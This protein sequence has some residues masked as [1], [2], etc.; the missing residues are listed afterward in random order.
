MR[1][2][3]VHNALRS[4]VRIDRDILAEAHEVDE[5]DL[6][7]PARIVSLPARLARTDIV[8]CWFASLHSFFPSV[9]GRGLS[10]PIISVVGAYDAANIPEIGFGHM[11]HPWKRHVVRAICGASTL[12]ICNSNY[13]V[14]TVR[15]NVRPRAPIRMLHHG[16]SFPASAI[17][18]PREQVAL[19]VG[20][21][22][23]VNLARKG[24]EVFAKA[25][26]LVPDMTFMLVGEIM[27]GSAAHLH[28]L[29]P[30]NFKIR[31]H[32]P[33]AE[34]DAL[35]LNA[36]VY[37][38]PSIHESFGL[39]VVEAMGA[40]EMPVVSRRGALPEVVGDHGVF[41]DE[42]SPKS[43]AAGI[44]QARDEPLAR[45]LAASAYARETFPLSK[46][47]EGLLDAVDSVRR[48]RT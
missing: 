19:T 20:Q 18:G 3:F 9:L 47:R 42:S 35:Y 14:E 5:L 2:L 40:G 36:L 23:R 1:I 6:S 25:A 29:A 12:V 16:V 10:K 44:R 33:Q 21:I 38:Q 32:V 48:R 37:V 4:F 8:F 13:A 22:R 27:D 46:R 26:A 28:S 41:V 15:R 30:R 17:D 34:L 45:R 11:G 31:D 43:V 7:V 39:T 24:H